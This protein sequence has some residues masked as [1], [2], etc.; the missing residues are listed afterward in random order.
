MFP[1]DYRALVAAEPD[2]ER[3]WALLAIM[4]ALLGNRDE[5]RRCADRAVEFVPIAAHPFFGPR[6]LAARAFVRA[7]TGDKAAAIDDYARL[8]TLPFGSLRN[9]GPFDGS[10]VFEMKTDPTY[11]PLRGEPAFEALLNDPKNR[12]PLF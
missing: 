8:L 10:S 6:N 3:A 12:A 11:A 7:W 2:N 5:A 4:E 9:I 1:A